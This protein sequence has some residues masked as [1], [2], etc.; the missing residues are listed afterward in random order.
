MRNILCCGFVWAC[1]GT[2]GCGTSSSG[3]AAKAT[4]DASAGGS[5]GVG[6]GS[7]SSSSGGGSS[8]SS[9]G[10]SSG[11]SS[12]T[13]SSSGG[14]STDAMSP[15]QGDGGCSAAID[16]GTGF[17][18]FPNLANQYQGTFSSPPSQTDTQETPDG[19]LLGNGDVGV[20]VLGTIDAMTFILG[21]NEFWSLNQG[22]VKAMARLSVSIPGMQGASYAMTEN[23][24]S[25]QVTGKFTHNGNT[26]QT[27]S[28]VQATDTTNNLFFTQFAYTGNTPQTVTASLAVG[29]Q[30]GN[31]A[32][33]GSMG[34]V[35]YEDVAGD[36]VD[37]VGGHPT[38]K[39]RVATRAIGAT[40]SVGSGGLTFTLS[41]G[42]T[43]TLASSIMSNIDASS[44]QTQSISNVSALSP[45][46]VTTDSAAHQAW[47]DAF[48]RT[49]YVEIAD[50][51]VE[52]EFYASLYLLASA[53]RE[54]EAPPGLWGN[55][56]MTDPAWNS[57]Y[58]L[59][60][61]FETPFYATF[62]TN[63]LQQSA[64]YDAPVI[65]WLPKAEAEATSNGWTGA[66]YRVHIGPLPNGSGDPSTHNQKF[67]GAFAVTDMLMHYYFAPDPAYA[68]SIYPTLKELVTFWQNYLVME[69]GVYNIIDD[70]QQE[71][72]TDPQTN[73][74]MSL[75]LVRFLLQ[76]TIDISTAL[77]MD[78][79]SRSVWKNVLANLAPFPTYTGCPSCNGET[80]F[81]YTSVGR[82]W[83]P[84][85]TIGIQHI[86]PGSQIGLSSDAN[87][88]K[89][90][91]NM[92]RAMA[93]WSDGNGTNTFYPAAA[94]VGYSPTT[95]LSQ[96]DSWIQNNTYPNLH[97]HT[98]GGGVE[99]L[100][101]VPST[102]AEML[103]Q[104]FQ[105]TIR[106]FA[107]WPSASNAKFAGL[108]AYGGFLV[109]SQM[110][111][112][113]VPYVAITSE[114]G[115][116]FTVMNPWAQG[117]V[118]VYRNG[119]DAPSLSGSALTVQTCPGEV[120]ILAPSGTSYASVISLLN[121]P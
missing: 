4:T 35:L 74:V 54:G 78:E 53:S 117:Q 11:S 115:G 32:S 58:T 40:G 2:I 88:L 17:A 116:S 93:R 70:A 95:I 27:T 99:N 15:A 98:G 52:K 105:G 65:A 8:G 26:I 39:V 86:Y 109:A 94:R 113:T 67:C 66:Y 45:S 60:Y 41:A 121:Q 36:N 43:V 84:G 56:V 44:Y 68:S 72:D 76:G 107:D 114:M 89:I 5:S 12:G 110:T 82:D 20:V 1:L 13:T 31:P 71:D 119:Q 77:G 85:N 24:G 106:V 57:D 55:W 3:G 100:N 97:I 28:W 90:A 23:I 96:L 42:Q 108:R 14:S 102:V 51:T 25:G 75:G 120:V 10:S 33:G 22:T 80:V 104:S 49:S 118:A 112:G 29:H 46:S 50:K 61:N 16:G 103:V 48:H 91:N 18:A 79:S 6:P 73:G 21:K 111:S 37:T 64:N 63:H 59:N 9:T 81:R 34:D 62:P 87:L 83:C 92:I 47:W 19:P 69:G 38:V 7:G 30:N 101:T